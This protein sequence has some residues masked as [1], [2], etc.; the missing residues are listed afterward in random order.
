MHCDN[1]RELTLG[2]G[3]PGGQALRAGL[4][5]GLL[6]G[7]DLPPDLLGRLLHIHQVLQSHLHAHTPSP[8]NY[9]IT[10]SIAPVLYR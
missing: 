4:G 9:L 10:N 6:F 7:S 3:L 8:G 1:V 2:W 5:H